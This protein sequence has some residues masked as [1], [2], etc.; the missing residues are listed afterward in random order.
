[1]QK[2]TKYAG[3]NC[4][5]GGGSSVVVVFDCGSS[6]GEIFIVLVVEVFFMEVLVLWCWGCR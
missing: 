4:S 6:G 5:V 2:K 3:I 1:M